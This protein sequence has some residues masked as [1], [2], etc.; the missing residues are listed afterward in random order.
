MNANRYVDGIVGKYEVAK[1]PGTPVYEVGERLRGLVQRWY[2]G[3]LLRVHNSGSLAKGTSI[4]GGTD[5]DLFISLRPR[6]GNSLRATYNGLY[7]NADAE[8]LNPRRQNVSIGVEVN[9]VKVD[10]VP[11]RKHSG[12]NYH[13]LYSKRLDSWIKTNVDQ[14]ISMVRNSGRTP[15]IRAVKIWRRNRGIRFPSFYLELAVLEALSGKGSQGTAMELKIA[16][17]FLA[18]EFVN[19]RFIDPVNE[20]NI[21]SDDLTLEE[22]RAIANQARSSLSRIRE[23]SW[24]R[25]LQ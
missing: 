10:L 16:L 18:N 17:E 19:A 9:N 20:E 15:T 22:K 5:L 11:A 14:H 25:V 3:R 23:G 13:S 8:G 7:Q 4:R 12:A 6:T 24:E 21:I 2:S 1:G